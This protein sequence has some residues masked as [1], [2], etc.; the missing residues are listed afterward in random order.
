MSKRKISVRL[1]EDLL[2]DFVEALQDLRQEID[3]KTKVVYPDMTMTSLLETALQ[4]ATIH[5]KEERNKM[6]LEYLYDE[7]KDKENEI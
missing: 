6:L 5:L 4:H 7:I 2:S 3:L 1:N